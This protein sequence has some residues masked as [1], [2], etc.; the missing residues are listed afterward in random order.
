M[1][2]REAAK[3]AKGV[4]V[5]EATVSDLIEDDNNRVIGVQATR[6][7]SDGVGSWSETYHADIT[8]IADGC[9][10]N[11]RNTV[12]GAA[13]V[14]GSTKSHFIGAVLE[15]AQLPMP[16]HGTVALVKGF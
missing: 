11:F 7:D 9:F 12:M 13:A 4:D 10:S 2:L 14:K 5:I 1:Q 15:D 8:I 6:K 3:R 16:N